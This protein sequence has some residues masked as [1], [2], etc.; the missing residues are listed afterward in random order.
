MLIQ[1]ALHTDSRP[2][3]HVRVNH[4]RAHIFVTQEFLHRADIVTAS[5]QLRREGMPQAMTIRA[6]HNSDCVYRAFQRALQQSFSHVM[7]LSLS[8]ARI[9]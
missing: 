4:R 6:F 3:Q 2:I 5:E 1:R 8:S 7:A 9:N